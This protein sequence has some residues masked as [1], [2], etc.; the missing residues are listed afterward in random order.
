MKTFMF[1][2]WSAFIGAIATLTI[3]AW[4]SPVSVAQEPASQAPAPLV[5]SASE[6]SF[7]LEEVAKH[8][9]LE[10]CWMV[11]EGSV[12]DITSYVKSHPAPP[13]VLQ[14]W[15]GKEATE[16]MRTKGYGADHSNSAW[17]MLKPLRVGV[18]ES[19]GK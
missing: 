9:R 15:C 8:N 18:L 16:G 14:R 10:D 13:S 2:A 7:T 5:S 1:A 17:E 12:Y 19:K 3:V 6:K 4:L 11:I